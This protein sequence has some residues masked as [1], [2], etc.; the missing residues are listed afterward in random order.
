MKRIKKGNELLLKGYEINELKDNIKNRL[1][2]E[3]QEFLIGLLD[4][5]PSE[6]ETEDNIKMNG[7][8]FT[9][10]GHNIPITY[11]TT[12]QSSRTIKTTLRIAD[13]QIEVNIN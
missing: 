1:I 13:Q 8:L 6:E 9:E 3:H 5:I 4:Y 2:R 10:T 7:Y 11:H 12:T